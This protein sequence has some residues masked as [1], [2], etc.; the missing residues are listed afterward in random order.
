MNTYEFD[1]TQ[2]KITKDLNNDNKDKNE[3][4]DFQNK[5][6][7]TPKKGNDEFDENNNNI[8]SK[9]NNDLSKKNNTIKINENFV[10]NEKSKNDEDSENLSKLAED[11]LSMSDD[12][13]IQQMRKKPI[14]KN[15]FIGE[16]KVFFNINNQTVQS[17]PKTNNNIT[18]NINH[19]PKLQSQLYISPLQKLNLTNINYM[20]KIFNMKNKDNEK[21]II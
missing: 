2:N 11:L 15:D 19:V 17:F 6:N 5:S 7:I 21:K 9:E 8:F 12:Y 13:H 4:I 1:N 14:D 18:D 10:I 3:I 20:N 16:S